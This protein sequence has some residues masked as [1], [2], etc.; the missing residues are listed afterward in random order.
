MTKHPTS[1]K[2]FTAAAVAAFPLAQR[3]EA[4]QAVSELIPYIDDAYRQPPERLEVNGTM[5]DIPSRLHFHAQPPTSPE[6]ISLAA[7]CLLTRATDGHLRHQTLLTMVDAT[8]AWAIPFVALLIGDYV[9]EIVREIEAALPR[10]DRSAYVNFV[11]ENRSMMRTLRAR[12]TSYWDAYYRSDYPVR[13][14]FP[15]LVVLNEIEA[16]VA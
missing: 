13:S 11:R 14:A 8:N 9:V 1:R 6:R 10:L 5:I 7:Q 4:E 2:P 3:R 12:T 15:G 16:W